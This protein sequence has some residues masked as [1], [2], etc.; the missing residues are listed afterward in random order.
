MTRPRDPDAVIAAWLEDGPTEL[1]AETRR[2][3]V[4]GVR[5][6]TRR[7]P[8][9]LFGGTLMPSF[10]R[11]A[12]V[13]VVALAAISV[14][15]INLQPTERGT[16]GLPSPSPTP[17]ASPSS[18][19]SARPSMADRTPSPLEGRA[20]R[21]PHPFSYRLPDG[22]G[23]V[24]TVGQPPTMYQFRIPVAGSATEWGNGIAVRVITGG[25]ADPCSERPIT[26]VPLT[27]GPGAVLDYLSSVPALGV[28]DQVTTAVSGLAAVR[29]TIAPLDPT[30]ACPDL[31]LWAEEGS[32][33]QNASWDTA[34]EVTVVDVGGDHVVILAFGDDAWQATARTFI[35]SIRFE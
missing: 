25:R 21:F 23:L 35:D 19:P 27:G 7:R 31:W 13:I 20:D 16:G 29:A 34:A 11:V 30:P 1:P 8:G 10:M 14:A 17:T 33:T 15:I 26:P 5:V 32:F 2:A 28:S 22:T 12:A 3:I 4:T 6:V 9:P 24:A 18:S